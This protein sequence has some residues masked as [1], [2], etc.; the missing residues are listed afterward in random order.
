MRSGSS[1]LWPAAEGE[2]PRARGER[3]QRLRSAAA[4]ASS[5]L[6]VPG[7]VGEMSITSERT[8]AFGSAWTM[9]FIEAVSR[10][11]CAAPPL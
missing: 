8:S 7:V 6:T 5:G 3:N 1:P 4:A 11:S 2:R 10:H 9:A